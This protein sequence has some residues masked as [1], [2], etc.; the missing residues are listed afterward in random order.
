MAINRR[1]LW[2]D[3]NQPAAIADTL[4]H[5]LEWKAAQWCTK[6]GTTNVFFS[7]PLAT[8]LT[9]TWRGAQYVWNPS[10][11]GGGHSST[12]CHGPIQAVLEQEAA[13]EHLHYIDDTIMWGNTAEEVF[14]KQKKYLKSFWK[15]VLPLNKVRSRG[16]HRNKILRQSLLDPN[17]CDQ[18]NH[19]CI[20]TN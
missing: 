5:E 13:Q 18:Q 2:Y 14:K 12:L 20:C 11:L 3:W 1:I 17:G 4:Q 19:T 16:L 10:P 7:I 15:L 9:C 6:T 8:E